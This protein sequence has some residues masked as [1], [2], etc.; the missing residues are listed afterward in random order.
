[1]TNETPKAKTDGD[2]AEAPFDPYARFI[3]RKG[4]S[5]KDFGAYLTGCFPDDGDRANTNIERYLREGRSEAFCRVFRQGYDGYAHQGHGVA[6]C[7][8]HLG[9][10]QAEALQTAFQGR[11]PDE[12][13]STPHNRAVIRAF[14][15]ATL[16][17]PAGYHEC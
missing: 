17:H 15:A 14:G 3:D 11:R 1:M 7:K 4:L 9:A 5:Y 16:A 2:Q 6:S 8:A 10:G 13:A 12:I